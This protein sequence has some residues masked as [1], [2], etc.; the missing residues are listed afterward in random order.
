MVLLIY[1]L[2]LPARLAVDLSTT[3]C[4]TCTGVRRVVVCI[5]NFLN[6]QLFVSLI[7]YLLFPHG[8]HMNNGQTMCLE[9]DA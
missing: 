6:E 3:S 9:F 4:K 2:L 1:L 5:F 7:S 8:I